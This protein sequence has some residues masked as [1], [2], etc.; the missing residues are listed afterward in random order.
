MR[1]RNRLTRAVGKLLLPAA[2][3]FAG[4][5]GNPEGGPI[6]M[7]QRTAG[8]GGRPPPRAPAEA[9]GGAS[10]PLRVAIASILSPS[11]TLD[12]YHDLLTYMGQRLGRPIRLYQ[13]GTYAEVND[14]L[15]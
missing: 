3:L 1:L 8:G 15:K 10:A 14:L 12:D 6:S 11:R 9:A 5:G 4:C 2:L 7:A 13:R